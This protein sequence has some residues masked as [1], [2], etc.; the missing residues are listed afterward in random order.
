MIFTN[1]ISDYFRWHYSKAFKELFHV[2]INF[3]W[4][5]TH[6]FSLKELLISLFSPWRR[7]VEAK[8]E[9][10]S[11]EGFLSYIIINI[12]SRLVGFIMRSGVIVTG[13]ICLLLIVALGLTTIALWVVLP[14]GSVIATLAGIS[15]LA[16]NLFI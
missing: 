16:S 13:T 7:M 2:W 10:W 4:F 15:L 14:V 5:I 11:F 6:F 9:G 8:Q 3:L 12:L 1:I